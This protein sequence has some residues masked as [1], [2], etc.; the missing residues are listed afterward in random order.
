MARVALGMVLVVAG[1]LFAG[2][3]VITA[4]P[5]LFSGPP[6]TTNEEIEA[7]A[8]SMSLGV[9]P[10][11]GRGEGFPSV[12]LSEHMRDGK[13]RVVHLHVRK[14]GG[15]EL[16]RWMIESGLYSEDG[17]SCELGNSAFDPTSCFDPDTIYLTTIRDPVSRFESDFNWEGPNGSEPG[18]ADQW[19]ERLGIATEEWETG[20]EELYKR[21]MRWPQS[22]ALL[23]AVP[24][25]VRPRGVYI[26]NYATMMLGA[27]YDLLTD[28]GF[29]SPV[30]T[31]SGLKCQR[32]PCAP[33]KIKRITDREEMERV[34]ENAK[35]AIVSLDLALP[36]EELS[37]D[38]IP[39][40]EYVSAHT[41]QEVTAGVSVHK[42][43]H[44][45]RFPEAIREEILADNWADQ[46]LYEFTKRVYQMT[47]F[48][49]GDD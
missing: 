49:V 15:G 8:L 5:L 24:A 43:V 42:N 38:R 39:F 46:E 6:R 29:T 7:A 41:G 44:K 36:M 18:A 21:W 22:M 1:L 40:F 30:A 12:A 19:A 14:S 27:D 16:R 2:F 13:G 37:Q 20:G 33:K 25:G 35:R 31:S 26:P 11:P 47:D 23:D 10:F 9:K 34:L 3:V 28:G 45:V 17:D 32:K 4:G 48:F